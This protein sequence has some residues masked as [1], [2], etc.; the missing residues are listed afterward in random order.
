MP[1]TSSLTW[2]IATAS[3]SSRRAC[4]LGGLFLIAYFLRKSRDIS[5]GF[6][7][8]SF[9]Q[10]KSADHLPS[11]AYP[12][13]CFGNLTKEAGKENDRHV[14]HSIRQRLDAG[15]SVA[16]VARDEGVSEPTVR[17]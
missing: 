11:Q 4:A 10:G 13:H 16:Q 9:T 12:S 15:D 7:A 14:N 3:S 2:D 6:R 17:K 5:F 8:R 1:R